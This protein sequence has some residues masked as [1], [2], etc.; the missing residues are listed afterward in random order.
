MHHKFG[1]GKIGHSRRQYT[2]AHRAAYEV[3]VGAIPEG[4][5]VR[6]NCDNPWCVNPEHLVVGTPADNM[7]DMVRRGR[8]L[9]G[10]MNPQA[11]LT[12]DDVRD[13]KRRLRA[14]QMQTDIAAQYGVWQSAIQK[15]SSGES[16]RHIV[17]P[18]LGAAAIERAGQ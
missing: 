16:W 10:K 13:I 4:L 3:F 14:G 5:H 8:S 2:S 1:Y 11:K 9:K 15:I 6:H 7:D 12:E 17:G 18:S